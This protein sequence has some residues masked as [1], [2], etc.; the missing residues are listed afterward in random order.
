[1]G[2]TQDLPDNKLY[3]TS[4]EKTPATLSCRYVYHPH[5]SSKS[6][7]LAKEKNVTW[8]LK[9]ITQVNVMIVCQGQRNTAFINLLK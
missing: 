1:M 6:S 4:D 3:G 5:P 7:K 2:G 8:L 9:V